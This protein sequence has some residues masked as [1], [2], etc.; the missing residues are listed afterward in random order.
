MNLRFIEAQDEQLTNH[1]KFALFQ[2]GAKDWQHMSGINRAPLLGSLKPIARLGGAFSKTSILFCDLQTREAFFFDPARGRELVTR[3]F[4]LHPVHVCL[5]A[6]PLLMLLTEQRQ[7]IWRLPN[8]VT[9]PLALVLSQPGLLLDAAGQPVRGRF[10]WSRRTP[11]AARLR[12]RE[13]DPLAGQDE[14]TVD[15]LAETGS[16]TKP[17]W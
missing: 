5:L 12:N 17:S 11:L 15:E 13:I 6:Y 16:S 14:L 3:D 7:E 1:G 2:F 4:L 10:E 8:V 9:L